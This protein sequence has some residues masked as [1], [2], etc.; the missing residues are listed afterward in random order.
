MRI[1]EGYISGK[2]GDPLT[3]MDIE[4]RFI[5]T[6]LYNYYFTHGYDYLFEEQNLETDGD[7]LPTDGD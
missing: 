6:E 7:I 4:V 1:K 2:I 3:R 5:P